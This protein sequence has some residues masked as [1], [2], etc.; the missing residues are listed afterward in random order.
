MQNLRN[1]GY[2]LLR[3]SESFF[4]TDMVYLAQGGFWL[5]MIT[6]SGFLSSFLLLYIFANYLDSVEYGIYRYLLSAYGILTIFTLGGFSTAVT[7]SIA[8][9]F[10]GDIYK[11]FRIQFLSSLAV[12]LGTLIISTYYFLQDNSV[13]GIGFLI[14][15]LA[16]P[17][18]EPFDLYQSILN[19]KRMFKAMA[20]T[21]VISNIFATALIILAVFLGGTVISILTIYFVAWI[22]LKLAFFSKFKKLIANDKRSENFSEIG[23]NFSLVNIISGIAT[24]IDRVLLFQLVGARELAIYSFAAAPPEQIKGFFKNLSSLILPKLSTRREEE[25]M[26]GLPKKLILMF[27]IIIPMMALYILVVP[28]LFDS[29]FPQYIESVRYSQLYIISLLG[30]LVI[31]INA[32]MSSIPKTKSLVAASLVT[33]MIS[34][35]IT[36]IL[37]VFYGL[38]GA[39]WSKIAIRTIGLVV[40]A[41]AL[42]LPFGKPTANLSQSQK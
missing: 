40:S 6:V 21:S 1:M 2:R 38:W 27:V 19:G 37:I 22:L 3:H 5:N 20:I 42:I 10:Y 17:I 11:A 16:L 34:I 28:V 14:I 32:A 35:P 8:K 25:I 15:A 30:L 4:K 36:I 26:A 7:R 33:P 13:L 18:M 23:I 31:P 12:S 24:Y 9:E 29:L 41:I 39:V